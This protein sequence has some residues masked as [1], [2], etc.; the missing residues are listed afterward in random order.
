M[1][2]DEQVNAHYG[3]WWDA[4]MNYVPRPY[5]GRVTMLWPAEMPGNP[6]WNPAASWSDLTPALDWRVVPGNHITM[7]KDQFEFVARE[8]RACIDEVTA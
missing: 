7:M 1:S 3:Y 5:P 4:W 8:L 2:P 6:P